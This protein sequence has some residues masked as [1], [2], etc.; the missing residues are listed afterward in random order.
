[1]LLLIVFVPYLI[2][3]RP[4]GTFAFTRH[5]LKVFWINCDSPDDLRAHKLNLGIDITQLPRQPHLLL[6]FARR[7][8]QPNV[9]LNNCEKSS[10]ATN[11][12][13]LKRERA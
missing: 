10:T 11:K 7:F 6:F 1:M 4:A 2:H 13:E 3:D 12:L 8:A 9:D 5:S